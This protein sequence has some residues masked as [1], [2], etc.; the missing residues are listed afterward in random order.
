VR[1]FRLGLVIAM[2]VA[3]LA[4]A[5]RTFGV[6]TLVS[7]APGATIADSHPVFT[8]TLPSSEESDAIYISTS[9]QTTPEGKFYDENVVD[10]EIFFDNETDW[11]PES[12]LAAGHYWW[13]VWSHTVDNL[14]SFYTAPRDFA[15]PVALRINSMR[16]NRYTNLNTLT[17]TVRW[18]SNA[19]ANT[20]RV[21]LLRGTRVLYGKQE[22]DSFNPLGEPNQTTFYWEAPRR[23]REGTPLRVE[24]TLEALGQQVT[25]SRSVRSP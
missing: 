6:A 7:P 25:A 16:V 5:P 10:L 18:T 2:A 24:I 4:A 22:Q 3:A 21:R 13:L 1:P 19:E 12:A 20:V 15:I 14:T 8:W 11:A 17:I 23:L 9:P